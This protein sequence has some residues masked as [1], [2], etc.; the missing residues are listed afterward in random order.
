MR[1]GNHDVPKPIIA[2]I[3]DDDSFVGQESVSAIDGIGCNPV[4]FG[5]SIPDV[6]EWGISGDRV[7]RPRCRDATQ[8]WPGT[9]TATR[10][11]P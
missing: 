5:R 3:D 1:G 9:T 7:R 11:K 8:E 4:Y 6:L 2:I 10:S